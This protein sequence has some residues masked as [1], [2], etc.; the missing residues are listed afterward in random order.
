MADLQT[1]DQSMVQTYTSPFTYT[2]KITGLK[3]KDEVVNGVTN[4]SAVVQ[5]YWQVTGKDK[6]GN[7]GTFSGATPFTTTTM[8][9]GTIF[10]PFEQLTESDVVSWV[11][12]VVEGNTGYQQHIDGQIQ[13]QI[14]QNLSVVS[15]ANLPW[16]P[17]PE[18]VPNP[19]PASV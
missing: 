9:E 18:P 6:S 14:D 13:K 1:P 3:V 12:G 16:A 15:E 7:E 17:A 11:K 8:P 19:G 5:T 4:K 2:Y 10:K